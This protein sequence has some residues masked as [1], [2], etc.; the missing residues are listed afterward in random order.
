MTFSFL[1]KLPSSVGRS[2]RC[3]VNRPT[4]KDSP[5]VGREAQGSILLV[6]DVDDTGHSGCVEARRRVIDDLDG[7]D[8][9]G[10]DVVQAALA[11]ESGE[12]RL[13][14]VYEDGHLVAPP[15]G[16]PTL[17]VDRDAREAPHRIEHGS[18]RLSGAFIEPKHLRVDPGRSDRVHGDRDPVEISKATEADLSEVV[19]RVDLG[20]EQVALLGERNPASTRG[21]RIAGLGPPD[22]HRR[23]RDGRAVRV[24]EHATG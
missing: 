11:P 23:Q 19:R 9:G 12:A 2:G 1:E 21:Q 8:V 6:D 17:L 7:F 5:E 24:V 22:D 15:K 4:P 20:Y 18:G 13:S 16:D 3:L 14:T 10:R